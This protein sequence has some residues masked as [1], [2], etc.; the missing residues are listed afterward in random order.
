MPEYVE[1]LRQEVES[2]LDLD[3]NI[4]RKAFGQLVKLDSI[5]KES[6]RFNPLLLSKFVPAFLNADWILLNLLLVTFERVIHT[7]YRLSDGFVIPAH[8]QIGIPTSSLLMDPALYPD[9]TRYDAFRFSKIRTHR[10]DTD[11]ASRA[12][13]AASSPSSMSFGFGRHACPGRFFAA[14]EIKAIMGYL[15]LN[16]DMKFP[17]GKEQRPESLL[18][19][20]QYLPN[21]KATVMFKRRKEM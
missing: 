17:E 14:N 13:Y 2:V 8:T 16:Y 4:D 7:P 3:G 6:Q 12:Q 19:E 1:P 21:S 15:L 18:F 20:T 10:A 11:A 5:M 9:P